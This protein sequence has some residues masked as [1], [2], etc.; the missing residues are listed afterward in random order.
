[1]AKNF[2][3]AMMDIVAKMLATMAVKAMFNALFGIASASVPAA[4][5]SGVGGSVGSGIVMAAEGGHI[6]GPGT[7]T[8]DS[9]LARLSNGEYVIPRRSVDYY[10]TAFMEALRRMV[11]PREHT[12]G[13]GFFPTATPRFAFA[14]GGMATAA[15]GAGG[16]P[17]QT[18]NIGFNIQTN[19]AAGFDQLLLQRQHMIEGMVSNGLR[20]GGVIRDAT[21]RYR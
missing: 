4:A 2:A 20:Q 13:F 18:I 1:M 15:A 11:V 12:R 9:I 21:R 7:G 3:Q 8:S 14:G 6:R 10:G 19:D 17:A 16:G 5:T